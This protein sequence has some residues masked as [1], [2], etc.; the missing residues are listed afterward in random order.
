[1]ASIPDNKFD[2]VVIGSGPGGYVAAIRAAQLGMTTAVVEM[3]PALGGTCLNWGCIP[4]KAML[5]AAETLE[6]ARRAASFGVQVAGAVLDLPK[7]HKFKDKTVKIGT[8][9]VEYLFKNNGIT[10]LPGRGRLAGTGKVEVTP[11]EGEAYLVEAGKIILAT[12]STI[13][14]LPGV[15]YD[16]E[17]IINSD[18]ALHLGRVPKSMVVL[19]AGAVGVEFASIYRSFGAEVTVVELLPRLI[20]LED[21]ALGLELAKAF[22]KRGIKAHVG[23]RMQKVAV[24][25]EGVLITAEKDSEPLELRTEV[26]LVAVGRR[27]ATEDLG[28]EN[29]SVVVDPRGFIEVDDMMRTAEENI[30]AI[31]DILKTPALAHVASHE[32][33]VAVEHAAGLKPHAIDYD[34]VPSCTYCH[35]EVASVGLSEQEARSRGHEVAVGSFPFAASG[36]AKILMETAGFIKI[37]ADKK[38]DRILGVHIIGA[39]ATELISEAIAAVNLDATATSLFQAMHAHPTLGE[40]MAEAALAVHERAIHL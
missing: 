10:H 15:E 2:M 31:G 22:K 35:P 1:M 30:Y 16:G 29:S 23:T 11:A 27:P 32:G 6:S 21:E 33:V 25:A 26:L 39:H 12:G 8:K 19:G 4:T 40:S 7:M 34:K 3:A 20:P 5:Q 38:D 18:H 28:L 13:M 24:D 9:G 17:N 36:K 14:A 37:V